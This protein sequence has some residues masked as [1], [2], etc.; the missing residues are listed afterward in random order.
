MK[1]SK[2][3]FAG[4]LYMIVVP[5]DN[6]ICLFLKLLENLL[7]KSD[8][9]GIFTESCCTFN[10]LIY[11]QMIDIWTRKMC[12]A[13]KAFFLFFR[14]FWKCKQRT[15]R[16][17]SNKAEQLVPTKRDFLSKLSC[18]QSISDHF[19]QTDSFL[20]NAIHNSF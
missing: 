2:L 19:I 20:S 9:F 6:A 10:N 7:H 8:I 15:K 11:K 12:S 1:M 13:N 16:Y 17:N 18:Q 14:T 3:G 4:S 5:A